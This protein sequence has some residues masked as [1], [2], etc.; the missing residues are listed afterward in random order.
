MAIVCSLAG[1]PGTHYHCQRRHRRRAGQRCFT[2]HRLR[3]D[4]A[5]AREDDPTIDGGANVEARLG[6]TV[7]FDLDRDGIQDAN[8]AE[9]GIAGVTVTL[10]F[11][12]RIVTRTVT[13]ANGYYT[14]PSL[15]PL[16]P[17]T[18]EF[19]RPEDTNWTCQ[20]AGKD[21]DIV[22]SDVSIDGQTRPVFLQPNEA[23]PTIDAG[24]QSTLKLD[25]YPTTSGVNGLVGARQVCDV[26]LD[27]LQHQPGG[28]QQ[29]HHHRCD[30][31]GH[32]L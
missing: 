30:P 22:D 17:Y 5:C 8:V 29:Y 15:L 7:W 3:P 20:D 28:R 14:F 13:Q 1:P 6:D 24:V 23:N 25:E 27:R 26:Y 11:G 32:H 19:A 4:R 21:F 16:V 2:Q 9:R 31:R 18:V 12:T 10:R